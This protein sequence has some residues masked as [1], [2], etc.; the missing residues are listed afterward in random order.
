MPLTVEPVTDIRSAVR[1]LSRT[2]LSDPNVEP[3]SLLAA[4]ARVTGAVPQFLNG[5]GAPPASG[6]GELVVPVVA[7]GRAVGHLVLRREDP[8]LGEAEKLLAE[9][10]AALIGSLLTR[11]RSEEDQEERRLRRCARQAVETLTVA[12]RHGMYSLLQ[13]WSGRPT[14]VRLNEAARDA[15]VHHS[16]LVQALA[17][18]RA[19]GVLQ[20]SSRG[21]RGVRVRVL[22]PYLVQELARAENP[23]R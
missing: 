10:T 9:S 16:S 11:R 19:A 8:P 2:A 17:K 1:T 20:A 15:G 4:L 6:R 18:L 3:A 5:T 7:D 23:A 13:D 12:E 14:T 21:R 22:N